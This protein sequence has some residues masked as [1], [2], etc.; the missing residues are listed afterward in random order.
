MREGELE[1]CR[2]TPCAV[3]YEGPDA[4]RESVHVLTVSREG[5]RSETRRVLASDA[6]ITVTLASAAGARRSPPAAP[7]DRSQA[8]LSG[9]R[10]EVPY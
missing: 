7:R 2:S 5:Y 8:L 6:T 10:L 9:Y 4:D 1:L 3:F